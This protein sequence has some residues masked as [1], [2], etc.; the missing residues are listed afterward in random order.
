MDELRQIEGTPPATSYGLLDRAPS[1]RRSH[2]ERPSRSG[3]S[4]GLEDPA[5]GTRC[6]WE[7]FF[8]G[9]RP[10]P[11]CD[12][13]MT[14][15]KREAPPR[16]RP[17]QPSGVLRALERPPDWK[18]QPS[19]WKRTSHTSAGA[20]APRRPSDDT[21]PPRKNSPLPRTAAGRLHPHSEAPPRF[22]TRNIGPRTVGT[23]RKTES[24]HSNWVP[25]G[26]L[27]AKCRFRKNR[28]E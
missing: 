15:G 10:G 26:S 19:S 21:L 13:R 22:R 17:G 12:S 11:P 16:T 1:L 28:P 18:N 27:V 14:S 7:K 23:D 8:R 24:S 5:P 4:S 2:P 3:G 9:D 6:P 25:T 20:Q